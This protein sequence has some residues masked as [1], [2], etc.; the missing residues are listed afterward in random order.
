MPA[1]VAEPAGSHDVFG[2]ITAVILA[3]QQVL[4]RALQCGSLGEGQAVQAREG[5]NGVPPH[6]ALAVEA[7][8]MLTVEG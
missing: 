5:R 8:A 2:G 7:S 3:R 1:R 4:G 6:E